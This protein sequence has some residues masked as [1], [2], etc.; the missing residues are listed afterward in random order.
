MNIDYKSLQDDGDT[1]EIDDT[2]R[3]VLHVEADECYSINDYEGDGRT[4]PYSFRYG[5]REPRPS[6]FT[7]RAMKIETSQSTWTWWEPYDDLMGYQLPD[8]T[9]TSAKWEQL[10]AEVQRKEKFRIQ[11]LCC[12]GFKFIRLELQELVADSLDSEHWVEL[13]T[14]SVSGCDSVYPE[15][16]KDLYSEI[17]NQI[18]NQL[19]IVT[20][21]V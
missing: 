20:E 16:I 5:D 4:A 9:W 1:L 10:P 7:G 15:L 18:L 6:G 2:H 3:L 13:A 17:L 11:E 19:D 14:N 12:W 21:K 8:G